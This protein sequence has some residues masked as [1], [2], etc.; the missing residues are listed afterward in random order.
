MAAN[1]V[2][3]V[4][5][6]SDDSLVNVDDY[7]VVNFLDKLGVVV[8]DNNIAI[9]AAAAVVVAVSAHN[10]STHRQFVIRKNLSI[11]SCIRKFF[12]LLSAAKYISINSLT[13]Y[14]IW[15][16]GFINTQHRTKVM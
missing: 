11:I 12:M 9:D 10:D 13:C 14:A 8:C 7:N 2:A 5:D 16:V 15:L 1:S 4:F 6:V 3:D